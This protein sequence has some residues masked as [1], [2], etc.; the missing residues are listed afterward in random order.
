M[1]KTALC[2]GSYLHSNIT[3][4]FYL[5]Q[6]TK[7]TKR[8]FALLSRGGEKTL[9]MRLLFLLLHRSDEA[10]PD[11]NAA[12]GCNL[13]FSLEST[14]RRF[15][16]K[17]LCTKK[18]MRKCRL[19]FMRPNSFSHERFSTGTFETECTWVTRKWPT[20]TR[21]V[22]EKTNEVFVCG[23]QGIV[24]DDRNTTVSIHVERLGVVNARSLQRE[25]M[26]RIFLFCMIT[27]IFFILFCQ[28]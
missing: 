4:C 25:W 15:G 20:W 13:A 12:H 28:A 16:V 8:S 9:G 21:R 10:Q 11:R 14:I 24:V 7:L 5:Y 17:C 19:I 26:K 6:C 27:N 2:E 18:F 22:E 23:Q 1:S 3:Q